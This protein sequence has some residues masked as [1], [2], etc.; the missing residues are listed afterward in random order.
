[1]PA[2][3]GAGAQTVLFLIADTGGGHRRV[4]EAVSEALAT[5]Y[6]GQVRPVVCDPLT[7]PAAARPLRWLAGLYGPVVRWAPWAWGAAYYVSNSRAAMAVLSRT[8]FA[9]ADRPVA[10]AVAATRPAVIVSCHP[11]TGQAALRAV[12]GQGQAGTEAAIPV[13]TVVTDL[14]SVHA[15]WRQPGAVQVAVATAQARAMVDAVL[16]GACCT[17]AGLPI[18]AAVHGGPLPAPK[19]AVLR[20]RLGIA[21]V[22]SAPPPFVVLL[23]GGAE[24]CGRLGRRSSAILRRSPAAHVVTVCGR[25]ERLRRRLSARQRGNGRLTVLGFV[26]NMPEWLQCADVV[27]T[28]AGPGIIAEAACCATPM[29][30]TSHLPGQERGN[31]GLV[32]RAGAGRTARG[33]R[34]MLGALAELAGDPDALTAL[35]TGC[36]SLARPGAAGEVADLIIARMPQSRP[37][38]RPPG[39]PERQPQLPGADRERAAFRAGR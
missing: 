2:N 9:L 3:A 34:A 37:S 15:S 10:K 38:P 26:G 18:G 35:R 33:I 39:Q 20:R 1:M 25:N 28:K 14:V 12:R 17:D 27:V 31:A 8:V 36:Q 32:V 16:D 22:A 6:P 4:A 19:R 5:R 30:L 21:G 29:L 23:T 11:L 13:L 24:G 7:G